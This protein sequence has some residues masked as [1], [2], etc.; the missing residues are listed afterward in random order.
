MI[1]DKNSAN[2]LSWME[3]VI[4]QHR[5][6]IY[7]LVKLKGYYIYV[8]DHY[9]IIYPKNNNRQT[10]T[11]S[12]KL[13]EICIDKEWEKVPPELIRKEWKLC[14]YKSVDKPQNIES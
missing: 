5:R 1:I 4:P 11:Q 13:C 9:M 7:L 2:N 14:G 3:L 8:Y 10:I 12:H 6:L